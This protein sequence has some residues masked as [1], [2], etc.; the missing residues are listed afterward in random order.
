MSADARSTGP[1]PRRSPAADPVADALDALASWLDRNGVAGW[2]PYDVLGSARFR[3]L[4]TAADGTAKRTPISRVLMSGRHR[5]PVATRRAMGVRPAINAKGVGLILGARLRMASPGDDGSL[6][7][8]TQLAKWLVENPS[9]GFP[10]T[11]WGYPFDWYTRVTVPA[12]TPS[13]VVTSTCGQALLDFAETTGDGAALDAAKGAAVFLSEGL[14]RFETPRGTC[15]SYTPLDDFQVY[16]ASLMAAEYL[17]RAAGTFGEPGWAD[18]AESCMRFVVADQLPDGSFEYWA[19]P[20]RTK[21]QIDNYHTGFVLRSLDAF[22]AAG[23]ELAEESL[24]RGWAYYERVLL[25]DGEPKQAPTPG[26]WLDIHSC[27]ESVLCPAVLSE[28][29]GGALARSRTAAEWT[30][31]HMR[32]ADGSF[33]HGLW[34]GRPRKGAFVRWAEAWMLRALSELLVREAAAASTG[35]ASAPTA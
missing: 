34:D 21:S 28:R 27:A 1:G 2:D 16:N 25:G 13:A 8:A 23:H 3:R 26:R 14:N 18:L 4:T 15:L 31:A 7:T 6:A 22:A 9:I 12:G 10:G 30:V 5:W 20:Q 35:D 29:F 17:L 24:T 32:N 33:V 11:S 19:P